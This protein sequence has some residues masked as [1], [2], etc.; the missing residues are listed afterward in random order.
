[1]TP[2]RTARP[3]LVVLGLLAGTVTVLILNGPHRRAVTPPPPTLA[4][5]ASVAAPI[6]VSTIAHPDERAPATITWT[7][8]PGPVIQEDDPR[9]N[10]L[11][12][13][14]RTCGPAYV[15]LSPVWVRALAQEHPGYDP[16]LCLVNVDDT[17]TLAC[18][19]GWVE[20]S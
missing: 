19:D 4:T 17:T 3:L 9:W 11:T 2:D 5:V 16:A 8:T 6:T 13:G 14:N 20:Q 15:A 10:C 1:M 7:N 18:Q 12:M